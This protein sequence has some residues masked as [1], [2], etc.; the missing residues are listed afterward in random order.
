MAY[1]YQ[2]ISQGEDP[3]KAL[4]YFSNSWYGYASHIC[5]DLVEEPLVKPEQETEDT[6][7]PKN[8]KATQSTFKG[9]RV[10]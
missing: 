3:W 5:P 6:Q 8:G 9:L 10:L 1:A 7:R 4:R 2:R